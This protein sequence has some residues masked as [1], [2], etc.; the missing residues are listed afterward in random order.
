MGIE[1][2]LCLGFGSGG[3]DCDVLR[4]VVLAV[5]RGIHRDIAMS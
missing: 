2:K 1:W 5:K 3:V 4:N